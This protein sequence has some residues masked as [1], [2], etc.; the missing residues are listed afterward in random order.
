MKASTC[1]TDA[2][3][4]LL[5]Y[6]H[7][8]MQSMVSVSADSGNHKQITSVSATPHPVITSS[9]SCVEHGGRLLSESQTRNDY[10]SEIDADILAP[11]TCS[12]TAV[13]VYYAARAP[14]ELP[15]PP[16][17]GSLLRGAINAARAGRRMTPHLRLLRGGEPADDGWAVAWRRSLHSGIGVALAPKLSISM[18]HN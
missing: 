9:T 2:L 8:S 15:F 13:L 3:F 12:Y 6:F 18:Q 11:S 4:C 7:A 5:P 16:P 14:V 10:R 1:W 17:Q